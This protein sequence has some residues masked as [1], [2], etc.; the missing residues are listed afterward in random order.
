MGKD[1]DYLKSLKD[2]YGNLAYNISNC[3]S[4]LDGCEV[5]RF[6]SRDCFYRH[7]FKLLDELLDKINQAESE[8]KSKNIVFRIISPSSD[9]MDE[10]RDYVCS[11]NSKL[12]QL[13][14][15]SKCACFKCVRDCAFDS[16]KECENGSFISICNKDEYNNRLFNDKIVFLTNHKTGKDF[17]YKVITIIEIENDQRFIF[18]ENIMD[19][20]DKKILEYEPKIT[21]IEYGEIKDKHLFDRLVSI[22]K[23][24]C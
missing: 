22:Y 17:R 9:K 14:N 1:L 10:L 12:N 11:I 21:G 13:E 4:E 2:K 3:L 6:E 7:N 8:L 16:C 19:S 15:C 23:E 24:C 5:K 18:L 20:R